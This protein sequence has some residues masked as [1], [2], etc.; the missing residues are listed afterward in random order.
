MVVVVAAAVA[1]AAA[2]LVL[3][4]FCALFNLLSLPLSALM[5]GIY[6]DD[7]GAQFHLQVS[8]HG[9]VQ[10]SDQKHGELLLGSVSKGHLEA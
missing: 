3:S 4:F 6:H 8:D 10:C 2:L 7:A 1:V 9:I 5:G